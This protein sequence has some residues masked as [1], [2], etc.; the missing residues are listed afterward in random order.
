M[1]VN[2]IIYADDFS[3][4]DGTVATSG[5]PNWSVANSAGTVFDILSQ[6]LR[7]KSTSTL[8]GYS[9]YSV[10]TLYV[11]TL[12]FEL[13]VEITINN[14]LE[15]YPDICFRRSNVAFGP[16]PSQANDCWFLEFTP[17]DAHWYLGHTDSGSQTY[18]TPVSVTWTSGHTYGIRIRCQGPRIR[19]KLWD[20]TATSS[21]PESW[22]YDFESYIHYLDKGREYVSLGALGGASQGPDIL[23]DNFTVSYDWSGLPLSRKVS[24]YPASSSG[25]TATEQNAALSLAA[26][27]EQA[28]HANTEIQPSVALVASN[29]TPG[30]KANEAQPSI[31]LV[32]GN[33]QAGNK[34]NEANASFSLTA[35]NETLSSSAVELQPSISFSASNEIASD[36]I[37]QSPTVAFVAN[38]EAS[39]ANVNEQQPSIS[40]VGSDELPNFTATEQDASIGFVAYDET[41]SSVSPGSATE[42][43]ATFTLVANNDS[44]STTD[45]ELQ[46]ATALAA[47]PEAPSVGASD[48]L[49]A[50]GATSLPESARIAA[51]GSTA[52]L[53]VTAYP[54]VAGGRTEQIP[55]LGFGAFD[56][57][58]G[59]GILEQ[60][61]LVSFIAYDESLTPP[62]ITKIKYTIK[63]AVVNESIGGVVTNRTVEGGVINRDVIGAVSV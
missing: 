29:E 12:D 60:D 16:Q 49:A 6:K 53:T 34:A 42:Q 55:V 62:V 30:N 57:I 31:T 25:S 35:N 54:S 1:P 41:A 7:I 61:A 15:Q 18:L 51:Q 33:E 17:A 13:Y 32:A 19:A 45:T 46:P 24:I 63:G 20:K 40:L 8:F 59:I 56:S 21:E 48:G 4:P 5:G 9:D 37:E 43:V 52:P 3:R 36:R 47:L 39:Q 26:S 58:P 50:F 10:G 44:L 23:F 27:N 38:H 14:T 2:G 11:P 22:G 28:T